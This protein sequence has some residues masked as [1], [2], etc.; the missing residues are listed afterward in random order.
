MSLPFGPPN[1]EL[2]RELRQV[3]I[4]S[5]RLIDIL[6]GLNFLPDDFPTESL[7]DLC[8][9]LS[10]LPEG[11]AENCR[12]SLDL[13]RNILPKIRREN[14]AVEDEYDADTES[15]EDEPRLYRGSQFDRQINLLLASVSTA[16]DEY[17]SQASDRTEDQTRAEET[18]SLDGPNLMARINS[19]T[20]DLK[21]RVESA[22]A[23]L[24][25][26]GV[27]KTE[28]GDILRR[29]LKDSENL[30][31]AARSQLYVQPIV[32]RW[33]ESTVIAFRKTPD[34]IAAAGRALKLSA[35][36]AQPLANWWARFEK[37]AL[38][39]LIGKVSELGGALEEVA[40]ILKRKR[41]DQYS[42]AGAQQKSAEVMRAEAEVRRMLLEG[43]TPPKDLAEL[44][45]TM[46]LSGNRHK[47]NVVPKWKDISLLQNAQ[48]LNLYATDFSWN[49]G[50]EYFDS[51]PRLE[52][53]QLELDP[54][55][56]E[57]LRLERLN[58]L[59]VQVPHSPSIEALSGLTSLT[60]L[61]INAHRVASLEP[62]SN[63]INLTSLTVYAHSAVSLEP[64]SSLAKLTSLTVYANSAMSLS[65]LSGLRNLTSLSVQ[66]HEVT[67]L[68]PLVDLENLTQLSLHVDNATDLESLFGLK[69]LNSLAVQSR[70]LGNLNFLTGLANLTR[71]SVG[72]NAATS[73]EPLS[74]LTNLT[75]LTLHATSATD[76]EQLLELRKLVSLT[77]EVSP[78]VNI[79][80][81]KNLPNIKRLVINTIPVSSLDNISRAGDI[82]KVRDN[83]ES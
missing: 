33:F 76:I 22:V 58:W 16:L 81:L 57:M 32:R 51:L 83:S 11:T 25:A 45:E 29:R 1:E 36:V 77:L 42:R 40:D 55:P 43:T 80:P 26:H 60:R 48:Y 38:D 10:G 73:L 66:A 46:N 44:V 70:M 65:P 24:D 5:A 30:S 28:S 79:A 67:N 3:A 21:V 19:G 71:L 82:G 23:E 7:S 31:R 54:M 49:A 53:L 39:S 2:A 74:G 15:E 41:G 8:D 20:D 47:R 35:E 34:L 56:E 50:K 68:G 4:E 63:L 9:A 61:H 6:K 27:P 17:R 52:R 78:S 12:V 69:K 75:S 59:T 37:D 72:M 14:F 62:L 64:L 18:G 13:A